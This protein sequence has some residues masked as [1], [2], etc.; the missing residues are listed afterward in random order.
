MQGRLE[1]RSSLKNL[2]QGSSENQSTWE[3]SCKGGVEPRQSTENSFSHCVHLLKGGA[4][5]DTSESGAHR[6][7]LGYHEKSSSDKEISVLQGEPRT[8]LGTSSL[9]SSDPVS[10]KYPFQLT[11][12]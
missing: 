7:S 9:A 3:A 12:S 4:D 6:G 5:D 10:S 8:N 11:F 1:P 2:R